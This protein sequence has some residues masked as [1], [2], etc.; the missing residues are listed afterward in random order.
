MR[1]ATSRVVLWMSVLS[2]LA[3]LF[4][5][6]SFAFGQS[7][8]A[9]KHKLSH[10]AAPQA[11]VAA[12]PA[13][14]PKGVRPLVTTETWTGGGGSG[15]TKW[16]DASNWNNGAITSGE[17]ILINTTTAATQEDNSPTIGTLTLSNAGDSVTLLNNTVLTVDGNITN[18]GTITLDATGNATELDIGASL[19]L[20]GTGTLVLGT[21]NTNYI[22]GT[23]GVTLTNASNI[24]GVGNIGNG[25]LVLAN[26]GTI[27]AF[28]A[29][30]GQFVGTLKDADNKPIVIN[31]L[32]AVRFGG[33]A[34]AD[35]ATNQLFF[36]AGPDNNN[37]GLFGVITFKP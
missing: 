4:A 14:T 30:T 22:L 31:Q 28:N 29:V 15:D 20:S 12:T 34:A 16:S 24:T 5:L 8:S 1:P 26:T 18:N 3:A 13:P 7:A 35:G 32:W 10:E 33:G 6:E 21:G 27:N 25:A 37:A 2:L 11:S 23:S 9:S 19:T 36:T 17:N